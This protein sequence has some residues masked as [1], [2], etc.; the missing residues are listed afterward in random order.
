LGPGSLY[1]SVIPNLLISDV[2]AA[3]LKTRAIVGYVSNV[4]TQ[5]GET[6]GFTASRHA[7]AVIEHSS[8]E[9]IDFVLVSTSAIPEKLAQAYL[10]EGSV[11]VES[12]MSELSKLP[13]S[14]SIIA[15]DLANSDNFVRHNSARLAEVL[16]DTWKSL[17]RERS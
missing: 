7:R 16:I 8:P 10:A 13:G 9:L 5:R 14:P 11:P 2:L 17:A 1:T 6:T 15:A 12:D 4:M 3:L